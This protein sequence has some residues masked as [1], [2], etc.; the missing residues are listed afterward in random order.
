MKSHQKR[1][2]KKDYMMVSPTEIESNFIFLPSRGKKKFQLK[3]IQF[4]FVFDH[5]WIFSPLF[6]SAGYVFLFTLKPMRTIVKRNV[7]EYTRALR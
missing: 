3:V 4:S 1:R 2:E 6:L 7:R 5:Q